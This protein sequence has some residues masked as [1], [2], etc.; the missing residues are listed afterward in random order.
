MN[1]EQTKKPAMKKIFIIMIGALIA[2]GL[3]FIP[4]L[5]AE[6][7]NKA[8]NGGIIEAVEEVEPVFSVRVTGAEY[9]TLEASLEVNGNIVSEH[10]VEAF[11]ETSGK[12]VGVY[13]SLGTMV[14]KGQLIAEIDPS[15]PGLVYFHSPVYA[16]ITGTVC[17]VPMAAGSTVSPVNSIA[18]IAVVENPE[19]E[20]LIP[21]REVSQLEINQGAQVTLQAFPHEIFNATVVRVSPVLDPYSRTKKIVLRFDGKDSRV[22]AGM[23]ARLKINTRIYPEV[24]TVPSEAIVDGYGKPSVYVFR[25]GKVMLREVSTGVT[26]NRLTEIKAGLAAGE[27]V[28]VQGQQFLADGATVRLIGNTGKAGG[29]A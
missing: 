17:A 26:I 2:A 9:R 14:Q 16:P 3:V 28:V 29:K 1:Q 10:Q 13:V 24:L 21:E 15:K 23:F 19:I 7:Q 25:D 22:N 8:N 4:S 20:A 27:Q 11:P 6:S 5:L 12:L 18:T